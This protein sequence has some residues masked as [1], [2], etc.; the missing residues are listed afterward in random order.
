MTTKLNAKP[1]MLEK[2]IWDSNQHFKAD[3]THWK[4]Y[5]N[6]TTNWTYLIFCYIDSSV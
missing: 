6:R 3:I 4:N 2:F 5:K 1:V